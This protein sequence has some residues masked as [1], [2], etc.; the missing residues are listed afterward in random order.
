MAK[1]LLLCRAPPR[2]RAITSERSTNWSKQSLSLEASRPGFLNQS[3]LVLSRD[4][5][6]DQ[7]GDALAMVIPSPA[8]LGSRPTR[9]PGSKRVRDERTRAAPQTAQW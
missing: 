8:L 7:H 5:P 6:T 3:A 4:R 1:R 2:V 9:H